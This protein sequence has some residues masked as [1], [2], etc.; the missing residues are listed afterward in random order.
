M[1]Y[2][3]EGFTGSKSL[4]CQRCHRNMMSQKLATKERFGDLRTHVS[5]LSLEISS[6]LLLKPS[7]RNLKQKN[8]RGT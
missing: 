1:S 4:K 2:L 3:H 5:Q 8:L 7:K 6:I